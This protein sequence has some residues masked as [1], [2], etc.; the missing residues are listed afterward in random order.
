MKK[1]A[2]VLI[3]FFLLYSL[4]NAEEN[5]INKMENND[6][7]I[8]FDMK[9]NTIIFAN[10]GIS[11]E[12]KLADHFSLFYHADIITILILTAMG[13]DVEMHGRWYPLNKGIKNFYL[14][15]GVGYGQFLEA[16]QLNIASRIGWKFLNEGIIMEPFIG[17]TYSP[18]GFS[19]YYLGFSSGWTF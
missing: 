1:T 18:G 15:L 3:L 5:S 4:I 17:Y 19:Q 7:S 14:S 11:F 8:M 10:I 6:Y 9:W 2:I 16:G 12:H 13:F